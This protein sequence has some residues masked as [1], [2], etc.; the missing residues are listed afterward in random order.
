M[1]RKLKVFRTPIGFHD[2]YVAAPSQ[3]AA[4]AA[5]GAD[6]NLFA[7]GVAEE[8]TDD[9]LTAEPF[10]RPGE[11]VRKVRGTLAEHMAALPKMPKPKAAKAT[12]TR[13]PEQSSV[14]QRP[15]PRPKRDQLA[16]AE[17]AVAEAQAEHLLILRDIADREAALAKERKDAERAQIRSLERLEK[18]RA[19][20]EAEYNAAVAKWRDE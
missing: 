15:K 16:A 14:R 18:A 17:A 5:W 6:A 2:A 19:Q 4:L 3:K 7:R 12:A 9:A 1:A 13:R 20:A 11:I 8:V 10:A